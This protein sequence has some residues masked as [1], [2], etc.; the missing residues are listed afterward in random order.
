[1][2]AERSEPV[3]SVSTHSPRTAS[4]AARP[5]TWVFND[6]RDP[7]ARAIAS[8]SSSIPSL[9]EVSRPAGAP[10]LPLARRV[11]LLAMSART[12][13]P[14]SVSICHIFGKQARSESRRASPPKMP[15]TIESMST[16]AASVPMRRAAKA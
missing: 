16:S 13:P 10:T 8:G 7:S 12:R 6:T 1:M 2:S 9:N 14:W 15:E 5:M 4:G 11:R 3:P